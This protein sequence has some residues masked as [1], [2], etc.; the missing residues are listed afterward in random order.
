[1]QVGNQG[2]HLLVGKPAGKSRHHA[3]ASK[4]ILAHRCIGSWN[5]TWQRLLIEEASE[6]GRY[7]LKGQIV[8]LV[9]VGTANLVEVL[10]FRLLWGE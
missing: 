1:M 6:I 5:A 7:F 8:V 9:A 3:S 2:G 4:H 10:P